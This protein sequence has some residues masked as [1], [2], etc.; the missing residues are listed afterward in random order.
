MVY[1]KNQYVKCI[2]AVWAFTAGSIFKALYKVMITTNQRRSP[3]RAT[4]LRIKDHND[5]QYDV[6]FNKIVTPTLSELSYYQQLYES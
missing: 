4:K 5:V 6:E 1:Y 2:E 3:T